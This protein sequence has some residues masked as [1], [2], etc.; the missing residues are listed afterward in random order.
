VVIDSVIGVDDLEE[1]LYG[2]EEAFTD[3]VARE[4][5]SFTADHID[6]LLSQDG[7]GIRACRP[8]SDN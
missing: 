6:T 1:R 5:C 7:G 3:V 2:G 4:A 8:P